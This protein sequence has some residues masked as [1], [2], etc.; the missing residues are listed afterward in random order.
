[1]PKHEYSLIRDSDEQVFKQS[2]QSTS[3]SQHRVPLPAALGVLVIVLLSW[4]ASVVFLIQSNRSRID[5]IAPIPL[6]N[7]FYDSFGNYC[8][9]SKIKLTGY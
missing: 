9:Y 8:E 5:G 2:K 3:W 6:N 7:Q 1:M 4:F